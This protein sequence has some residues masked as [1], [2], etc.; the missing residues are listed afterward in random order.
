[1]QTKEKSQATHIYT[2][3][4]IEICTDTNTCKHRNI[5]I[6][7]HNKIYIKQIQYVCLNFLSLKKNNIKL[8]HW[9]FSQLFFI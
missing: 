7:K 8:V 5:K 9:A 4:L 1:M 6:I 2:Q 3:R